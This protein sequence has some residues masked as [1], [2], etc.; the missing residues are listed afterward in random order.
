MVAGG[1]RELARD[2][3]AAGLVER[4]VLKNDRLD[5]GIESAADRGN[6]KFG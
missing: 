4:L 1:D 3:F 2:G 5:R 6:R